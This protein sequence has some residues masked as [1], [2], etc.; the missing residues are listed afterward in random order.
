MELLSD[1]WCGAGE[2][3]QQVKLLATKDLSLV[4]GKWK[5]RTD[6][7]KLS[8]VLIYYVPAPLHE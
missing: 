6:S 3:A 5:V 2:I 4:S 1:F 8:S 7:C